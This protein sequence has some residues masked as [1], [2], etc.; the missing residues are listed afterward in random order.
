[1]KKIIFYIPSMAPSG[2]IERVVSILANKLD[3][4]IFTTI[5]TKDN[6]DYF[7]NVSSNTLKKSLN[8]NFKLNMNNRFI[9]IIQTA[10]LHLRSIIELKKFNKNNS[11]D[12]IY[13]THPLSQLECLLSG[14]PKRK[15]I[16]SEHGAS[17]NYNKMYR[18]IK[19]ISYK[20]CNSYCIPT[21]TD[22]HHYSQQGFPAVYIP[23]FRPDLPYYEQ[24]TKEKIVLNIGR[25]TNDKN[26]STLIK[27]WSNVVKEIDNDWLLYIVGDGELKKELTDEINSL[28]LTNRVKL[29]SSTD[30]IE[31]QY[32]TASVFTL[33][34]RSEGFGM[35]L[36]EAIS[37]GLPV[38]SFDCPSGPRDIII[39]NV[40]G[41][42]IKNMDVNEYQ[43]K[44]ITLI[45]SP[46]KQKMMSNA[47]FDSSKNW[48][49][50]KIIEL[51]KSLLK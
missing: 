25:L 4:Y 38:I 17:D 51:W 36:L 8:I 22:F 37:F 34:S 46:S 21:K 39:N 19:K 9:R 28:G 10:K 15:I 31:H 18:L 26:Q 49:D 14:I 48:S 7:Y 42:L 1:M 45:N 29:L 40:N 47:A 30:K 24:K 41:F 16:I 20:K 13:I 33:T 27:I 5:L 43:E 50:D 11:F 2:G 35:V 23:H 12:F 44:L 6:K 3:G 32:Q